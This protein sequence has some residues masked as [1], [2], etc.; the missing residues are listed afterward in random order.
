[1]TA[2]PETAAAGIVTAAPSM[3]DAAT[4]AQALQSLDPAMVL[5]YG[6]VALGTAHRSSD[7]DICAVFDDLDDYE[8]RLGLQRQAEQAV[9][10]A[11]GRR[12]NVHTTDPA[13]WKAMRGCVSSFE[14]HIAAYAVVL[15]AREPLCA[16]N[17][18]KPLPGP[19]SDAEFAARRLHQL[20]SALVRLVVNLDLA[21]LGS[22]IAEP[23]DDADLRPLG[24]VM[25]CKAAQVV[26]SLSLLA[27][28]HALP[29]AHVPKITADMGA[30]IEA[31]PLR[32]GE[33]LQI[34]AA[35][36]AL[37]SA[38]VA[39]WR[40]VCWDDADLAYETWVS[41]KATP[42][43]A[44][45]MVAAAYAAAEAA[46]RIVQG[47]VGESAACEALRGYLSRCPRPGPARAEP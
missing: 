35:V 43:H 41:D 46:E 34:C 4:A 23:D 28:N 44:R 20:R 21:A 17:W 39:L 26:L 9:S 1:M 18:D 7:I 40:R 27:V 45:V 47:R 24:R 5:L 30:A 3:A 16:I 11:T 6:S 22:D 8:G 29:G 12:A 31:M 13:E 37:D 15:H 32:S 10:D 33:R 19:A 42:A 36:G 38:D 14:R 25:A 2:P